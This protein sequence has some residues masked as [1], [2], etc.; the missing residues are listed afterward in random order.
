[1][2]SEEEMEEHQMSASSK[3]ERENFLKLIACTHARMQGRRGRRGR[4]VMQGDACMQVMQVT[5][6]ARMQD[7]TEQPQNRHR[8]APHGMDTTRVIQGENCWG[9]AR[10][11]RRWRRNRHG[12]GGGGR[13]PCC[14]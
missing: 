14:L 5:P 3:M 9:L 6:H 1:M 2:Y 12:A 8:T 4:K 13:G 11:R 7:G 10:H